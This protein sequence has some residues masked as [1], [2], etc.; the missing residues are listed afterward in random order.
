M[1]ERGGIERKEL[2][3]KPE[4]VKIRIRYTVCGAKTGQASPPRILK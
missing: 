1:L 4:Y 2:F 3:M